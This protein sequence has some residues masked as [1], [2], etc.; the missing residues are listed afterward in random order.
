MLSDA[1]SLYADAVAADVITALGSGG[2]RS[3]L[4]RGPA[5]ARWLYGERRRP[6]Q[7]VDLL[8]EPR[9]VGR[10]EAILDEL[11][12]RYSTVD[13]ERQHDRPPHA[14]TWGRA[15]DG[16]KVDL[17]QKVIGAKLPPGDVWPI[18]SATTKTMEL[19]GVVIE[20]LG[21]EVQAVVVVL[22]AAQHGSAWTWAMHD[23]ARLLERL[24]PDEWE[25]VARLAHR[26]DAAEAFA[27]GLRLLPQGETV[28][29]R[30]A[31]PRGVSTEVVLRSS[32]PPPLALGFDWL[33]R[34][35]G[36]GPKAA[37][38][39]RKLVPAKRF[40]LSWSPL[41]ARGRVGLGLAYA[42][43]IVWLLVHAG[44]GLYAWA[45]AR[46]EARAD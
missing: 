41:A 9:L 2:V 13:E 4:L 31:L 39:G 7:D 44:P 36:V 43:R 40:M 38:L 10:A 11:G 5:V 28:A 30:L 26:L 27:A 19:N 6:Y 23:L 29:H 21:S 32:T 46:R 33:A 18:L 45:R 16:A 3:I 22:H 1:L 34:T 12:F 25:A 37:L 8:V 17:H 24:Q 14:R 15:R 20:V 35:P 42:W